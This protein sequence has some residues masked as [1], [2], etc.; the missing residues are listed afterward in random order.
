M[1][2]ESSCTVAVNGCVADVFTL[3]VAGDTS[4]RIGGGAVTVI[5]AD[6]DFVAS[7]TE[8]AVSVT[9]EPGAVGG[10]AYVMAAPDA[11]LAADRVPQVAPLQPAPERAQLTPLPAESPWT[12][13][14]N[15]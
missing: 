11:L 12:V 10:A 6:A 2:A 14:V 9:G 3:A 8:V 4:T 5:V 13:A 7:A 1:P 15:G